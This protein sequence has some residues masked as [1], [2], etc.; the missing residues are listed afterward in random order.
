[1][2][3][4]LTQDQQM[5]ADAA[6][7]F[8]RRESTLSRL[9]QMRTH[10]VGWEKTLWKRMAEQGWPGILYPER[11]GGIGGSMVDMAQVLGSLATTLTPEPL[12]DS[13]ILGGLPILFAGNPEQQARWLQPM[14]AG[15]TTLALAYAETGTRYTPAWIA[16]AAE[17]SAEG[18]RITGEKVFVSNGVAADAIVVAAR[19]SGHPGDEAGLTLFVVEPRQPG[20]QI[21]PIAGIDSH[22]YA[23]IRFN[24]V[25]IAHSARLGEEGAALPILERVLDFGATA[26]VA[27]GIA[28]A[29]QMLEMTVEYL[30]MRKQFGVFIGTFQALQHRAVDMFIET[31]LTR[32]AAI[33]AVLKVGS[34]DENERKRAVSCAKAQLG[35][36]GKFVSQQAIQLHGGIGV[37]DEHDIGL[38]FKRMHVLQTLC[39]DERFHVERVASLPSFLGEAASYNV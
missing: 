18:Y 7:Q 37:A 11:L 23:R 30:K 12:L 34:S 20:V 33:L 22:R 4:E 29:Q 26:C 21:E 6:R 3:F 25:A 27:E 14:I 24:H 8:A 2:D 13:A 38:F 32:S 5:L 39:G 28:I 9:R 15:D 31:E 36:G 10:P 16:C 35:I 1:M 19:T 17:R